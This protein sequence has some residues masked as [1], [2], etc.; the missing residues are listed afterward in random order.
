M[1]DVSEYGG[2]AGLIQPAPHE[3]TE[4]GDRRSVR[5]AAMLLRRAGLLAGA[6]PAGMVPDP[7]DAI[8]P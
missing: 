1:H 6:L 4:A 3:P 5:E 7:A 2:T 8:G